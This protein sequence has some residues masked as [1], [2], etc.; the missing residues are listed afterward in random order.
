MTWY[1]CKASIGDGS[2][3]SYQ[4]PDI[5]AALDSMGKHPI[6]HTVVV[7][8]LGDEGDWDFVVAGIWRKRK[9]GRHGLHRETRDVPAVV[10][11]RGLASGVEHPQ[12]DDRG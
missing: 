10:A 9:E 6:A 11:A 4:G 5:A 7:E 3:V 8:R 2:Y 12:Q 1:R